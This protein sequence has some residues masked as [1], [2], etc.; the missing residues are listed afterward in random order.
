[1]EHTVTLDFDINMIGWR[2]DG[3]KT[4]LVT[5]G[6]NTYMYSARTINILHTIYI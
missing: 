6:Y 3:T 1:M 4:L 5:T 2:F